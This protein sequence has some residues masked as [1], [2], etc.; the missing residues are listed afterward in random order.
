MK[1]IKI[2]SLFIFLFLFPI[3]SSSLPKDFNYL[4]YATTHLKDYSKRISVVKGKTNRT[5]CYANVDI[6][7]NDTLFKYDKKDVLSSETCY[8]PDKM[9]TL[10]NISA[11]TNDT[12]E[13]NRM[14]LSFCIY[15]VLKDP[16]F[17]IQISEE[18]KFKILS[19]PLKET[20]HAELL[21]DFPD[22]NEFLIAG[23]TY[24]VEESDMI[25]KIIDRNL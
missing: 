15:Y 23:T 22:L 20:E 13:K 11:Y 8:C 2:Y 7:V 3:I 19:L 1:S 24:R 16:E 10:K 21:F 12:Y 6:K 14:L 25:E 5:K 9:T 18:E 4:D 17:I